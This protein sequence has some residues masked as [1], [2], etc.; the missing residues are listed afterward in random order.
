[1]GRSYKKILKIMKRE[2]RKNAKKNF[3]NLVSQAIL[4][5]LIACPPRH[6][7]SYTLHF[8]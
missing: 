3:V 4:A 6:V 1:M 2:L 8:I 7:N 5:E